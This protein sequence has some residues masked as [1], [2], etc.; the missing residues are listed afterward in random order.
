[1]TKDVQ[2]VAMQ[3]ETKTGDI[4]GNKNK[5]IENIKLHDKP[6]NILVFPELS[7]SGYNCGS[8]FATKEFIEAEREAMQEIIGLKS[9]A[10]IIIGGLHYVLNNKTKKYTLYNSAFVIKNGEIVERYDKIHLADSDHHDD[11]HWFTS[12]TE[13]KT[14]KQE[15]MKYGIVIC[16]D[17]WNTSRD[18]Y[19]EYKFAGVDFIISIN[20][21]YFTATKIEERINMFYSKEYHIPTLY[22]NNVGVGDITKNFF[23]YDGTS[24]FIDVERNEQ[25]DYKTF[26]E[27]SF[28]VKYCSNTKR[29]VAPSN[30]DSK[31][32]TNNEKILNTIVY[33]IKNIVHQNGFKKVQVHMSGGIDSAVVGTLAVKALGAENVV[34]ISNPSKNNGAETKGNAQ[35]IADKCGVE[36]IWNPITEYIDTYKKNNPNIKDIQVAT[37]EATIR[38]A[39]GLAA[40]HEHG[41]LILSCGNHT[42]NALGFFNFHDIGSIGVFQPIGDLNKSQ[43]YDLAEFINE[44]YKEEL[45]P[46]T[47]YDGSCRPSAELEDNT[48]EDPYDYRIMSV[49][50]DEIVRNNNFDV[51]ELFDIIHYTFP[52]SYELKWEHIERAI[53]LIRINVYKRAQAAPVLILF[54]GNSFGFSRRETILNHFRLK[55]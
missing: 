47:L 21:S 51:E 6:E 9:K 20:N 27:G 44:Y 8:L 7:I 14:I 49:I 35:F 41:T 52:G 36:L 29:L 33:A 12:G 45:I 46:K 25:F 3:I 4:E 54:S 42:E 23:V 48:G 24:F 53:R 17:A 13:I 30:D 11:S 40:T 16:E 10:T 18:L 34:M 50:C 31:Y 22:V 28:V 39:L 38:S 2:I 43:V 37:F 1:M 5:V 15:G 26:A 19:K 32:Y 55:K